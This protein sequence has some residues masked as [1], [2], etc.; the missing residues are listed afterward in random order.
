[1][2]DDAKLIAYV[3]GEL[4]ARGRAEVEAALTVDPLLASRLARHRS[5]QASSSVAVEAGPKRRRAAGGGGPDPGNIVRLSDRRNPPRARTARTFKWPSW[6]P[7]VASLGAGVIGGY[8]LSQNAAGPLAP[9]A[10]GVLVARG[11]L[12]KALEREA[13]DPAG[14]VRLSFRAA[15]GYCRAFQIPARRLA[16]VA[17]KAGPDWIARMTIQA[18]GAILPPA[19]LTAVGQMMVGKSLDPAAEAA[20]RARGW[21]G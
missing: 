13:S 3:A 21:R 6:S 18:S 11:G 1:M 16:G 20:A 19:V 9:R 12:A 17:C 8:L 4:T 7:I 2:I 5:A 14:Q 10:D 15:G